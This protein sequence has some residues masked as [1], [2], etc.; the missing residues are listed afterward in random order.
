M[1]REAKPQ[2]SE[3]EMDRGRRRK[4]DLGRRRIWSREVE[5]GE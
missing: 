2:G 3:G 1:D 5:G 4:A